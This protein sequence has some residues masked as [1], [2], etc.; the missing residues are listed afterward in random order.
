MDD[1]PLDEGPPEGNDSE[2]EHPD[3]EGPEGHGGKSQDG[4][5]QDGG[6]EDEQVTDLTREDLASAV[7]TWK[8]R[9]G[10]L[11]NAAMLGESRSARGEAAAEA[12]ALRDRIDRVKRGLTALD[13]SGKRSIRAAILK[14]FREKFRIERYCRWHARSKGLNPICRH[15]QFYHPRD[16]V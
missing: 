15:P 5:A 7:A 2:G 6:A 1:W 12:A 14:M 10:V 8:E 16:H 11:E 3:G 4:R 9:I 13:E